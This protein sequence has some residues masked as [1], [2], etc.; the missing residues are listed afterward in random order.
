MRGSVVANHA[1]RRELH[2]PTPHRARA[3]RARCR[4]TTIVAARIARDELAALDRAEGDRERGAQRADVLVPCSRRARSGT[5]SA[6]IDA[7]RVAR[8]RAA[9]PR[10]C[11]MSPRSG[12]VRGEAGAEQRVDDERLAAG[13]RARRRRPV[14]T[15]PAAIATSRSAIASGVRAATHSTTRTRTP[16]ACSA[17]ATTHPSPPLLPGPVATTTPRS[18]DVAEAPH[19]LRRGRGAGALH[20]RARRNA[21][22][23]R[24]RVAG[25]GAVAAST[26]A[27]GEWQR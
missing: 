22:R 15:T 18:S 6:T 10:R 26:T 16:A 4:R 17:C 13:E 20:Q 11:A 9:A 5:S 24:R 12:A 8:A 19:D 3:R 27:T 2:P 7:P 1:R 25:R 23:D 14:A 21:A